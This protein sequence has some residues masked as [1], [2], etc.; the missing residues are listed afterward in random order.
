M[1]P[2]ATHDTSWLNTDRIW[3]NSSSSMFG[4]CSPVQHQGKKLRGGV[5]WLS[6][7][8]WGLL[9]G[10]YPPL[11]PGSEF[12]RFK[13]TVTVRVTESNREKNMSQTD[14]KAAK[15]MTDAMDETMR[16]LQGRFQEMS[17]QLESKINEM[18]I[19]IDDLEKNVSDLMTQAGME[20]QAISK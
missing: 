4:Q 20:E 10:G 14:S 1:A 13:P 7:A 9:Y 11:V 15:D 5:S 16:R 12:E 8:L 6:L 17:E 3:S 19:R 18:G 2:A